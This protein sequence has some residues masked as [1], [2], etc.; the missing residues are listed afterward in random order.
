MDE[1]QGRNAVVADYQEGQGY[2]IRGTPNFVINGHLVQ[3]LLTAE[4]FSAIID[5]LL[6]EA[7]TGELPD[8]V[9]TVTPTPTP[10]LDFTPEAAAPR[11]DPDA[12][13]TIVEFSD[14]QCPFCE[15][16]FQQTM[17]SLMSEYIDAGK[18]KYIFKDF[19]PTLRNPEYHPQAVLAAQTAECAG[20]QEK[21]WEM[22]DKLYTEQS[23]WA[24]NAEATT[25]FKQFAADL[26]LD[27]KKFDACLDSGETLP[28]IEQDL[29]DGLSAGVQGTPAFFING[30][31]VSG[32]QPFEVFKQII[33][34][35]LARS[36]G[37]LSHF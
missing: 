18:V 20:A 7:E 29:A 3:G 22:H 28:E 30:T 19:T 15:R 5:A 24:D 14:Y 25:V 2:G 10:N 32:A 21:Y 31:F 27:Q 13:V 23:K 9:V 17:P 36:R 34:Q 11:G 33:D 8:T 26:K 37:E 1:Q 6:L 12:P 4:Q 16:H 35:Q